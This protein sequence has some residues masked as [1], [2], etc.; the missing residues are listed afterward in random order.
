[1]HVSELDLSSASD[2]DIWN[3]ARLEYTAILTKDRDFYYRVSLFGSPPKLVWVKRGNCRNR[4][5]LDL[6]RDKLGEIELFLKSDRDV[7]TIQ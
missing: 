4:E 5:L 3:T 1:M 7:M 2:T 6:I